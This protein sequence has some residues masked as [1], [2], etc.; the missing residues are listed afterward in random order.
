VDQKELE[1][2]ASRLREVGKVIEALPTE[3]RGEAF[4]LL[5]SYI[6]QRHA[7][8]SDKK[9]LGESNVE[10]GEVTELFSRFDH[11][12]P[13][14]NVRLI[15]AHFFQEYGSEPFS[16][17]EVK[18]LAAQVGITIS[19]RVYMT[20]AAAKENGKQLFMRVG[21]GSFKPTVHGE[22]YLKTTYNVKK[23]TKTRGQADK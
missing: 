20:L 18:A 17:E 5:K 4:G 16:S 10:S 8:P 1:Q 19:D 9:G 14:D 7:P 6:S 12:K 13:S 2:L 11:D 15:A 3:I 23:D 22:A 21:R